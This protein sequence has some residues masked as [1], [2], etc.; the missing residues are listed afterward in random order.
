MSEPVESPQNPAGLHACFGNG[1]SLS[2]CKASNCRRV[3]AIGDLSPSKEGG[4]GVTSG[5]HSHMH[6]LTHPTRSRTEDRRRWNISANRSGCD[7]PGHLRHS[8]GSRSPRAWCG[9]RIPCSTDV[10]LYTRSGVMVAAWSDGRGE[11]KSLIHHHQSTAPLVYNTQSGLSPREVPF[12]SIDL[13]E[14]A[15]RPYPT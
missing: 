5:S 7:E 1:F 9:T 12:R 15:L 14:V 4:S 11:N 6:N 2:P 8:R 3:L 10:R 13:G